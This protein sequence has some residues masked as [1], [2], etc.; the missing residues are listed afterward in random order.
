MWFFQF[1]TCSL[2]F[3]WVAYNIWNILSINIHVRGVQEGT[4]EAFLLGLLII[5]DTFPVTNPLAFTV[6]AATPLI[7]RK[8]STC[9]S[10]LLRQQVVSFWYSEEKTDQRRLWVSYLEWWDPLI[11]CWCRRAGCGWSC[12]RHR[13]GWRLWWNWRHPGSFLWCQFSV[14]AADTFPFRRLWGNARLR[15]DLLALLCMLHHRRRL[16]F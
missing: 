7:I 6:T 2:E 12:R 3:I 1:D 11:C 8:L 13:R 16:L 15:D 14:H 9:Q 5:F 4:P 10:H